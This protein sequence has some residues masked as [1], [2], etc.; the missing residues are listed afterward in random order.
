MLF[1]SHFV[2]PF[3]ILL[4]LITFLRRLLE[5]FNGLLHLINESVEVRLCVLLQMLQNV[6]HVLIS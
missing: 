4:E 5:F 3:F 2:V 1:G 6:S